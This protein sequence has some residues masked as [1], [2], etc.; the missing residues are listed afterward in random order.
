MNNG[1]N[2]P[3]RF[4]RTVSPKKAYSLFSFKAVTAGTA[5]GVAAASIADVDFTQGAKIARAVVLTFGYATADSRV[6]FVR[7]FFVHHN[8]ILL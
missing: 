8:S 6:Y 4:G 7:V 2:R 1:K 3:T 5:F